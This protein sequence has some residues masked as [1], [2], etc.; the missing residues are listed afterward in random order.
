M[1]ARPAE[2]RVAAAL[3]WLCLV[4][5]PV[6]DDLRAV[7]D[8]IVTDELGRLMAQ[9]PWMRPVDDYSRGAG[10]THT[11]NQMFHPVQHPTGPDPRGDPEGFADDP[12]F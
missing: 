4:D 11:L 1:T 2:V 6:P 7:L 10:P 12:P 9:V 8:E 3:G 5:D